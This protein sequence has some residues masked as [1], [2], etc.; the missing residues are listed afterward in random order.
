MAVCFDK[1]VHAK[2]ALQISAKPKMC[3]ATTNQYT[4]ADNMY[5]RLPEC[6]NILLIPKIH[7]VTKSTLVKKNVV[8]PK[9]SKKFIIGLSSSTPT[10]MAYN[11]SR[12]SKRFKLSTCVI[13]LLFENGLYVPFLCTHTLPTL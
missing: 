13:R 12:A 4:E 3:H 2:S 7:A 9:L 1:G 8:G 6:P 11:V 5:T 10:L